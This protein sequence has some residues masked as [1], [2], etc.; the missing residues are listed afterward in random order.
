MKAKI[1][2]ERR[3]DKEQGCRYA[4]DKKGNMKSKLKGCR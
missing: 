3:E 1:H 2:G 4:I